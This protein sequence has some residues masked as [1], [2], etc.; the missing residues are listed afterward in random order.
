MHT[1]KNVFGSLISILLILFFS[2]PYVDSIN[3]NYYCTID[4]L[5]SF[6]VLTPHA[7]IPNVL[8]S[9]VLH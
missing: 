2:D 1:I 3:T 6:L 4:V 9:L 8:C 5:I 7:C